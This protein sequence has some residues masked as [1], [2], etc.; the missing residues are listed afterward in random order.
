[1]TLLE[2]V[3][4]YAITGNYKLKGRMLRNTTVLYG[5]EDEA[6]ARALAEEDFTRITKVEC[7][8]RG[9]YRIKK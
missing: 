8:G 6:H 1:M 9:H 3:N 4:G 7:L 2:E 5:A